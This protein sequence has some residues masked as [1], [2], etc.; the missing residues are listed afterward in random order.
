MA[1]AVVPAE[2]VV[3]H[4]PLKRHD[5]S[6]DVFSV[7]DIS[8]DTVSDGI[9]ESETDTNDATDS[10]GDLYLPPEIRM[11]LPPFNDIVDSFF[12]EHQNDSTP[13]D[14]AALQIQLH[15]RFTTWTTER[16]I[17]DGKLQNSNISNTQDACPAP[18]PSC[19]SGLENHKERRVPLLKDLARARN[20]Y[21]SRAPVKT[22]KHFD[23]YEQFDWALS[24]VISEHLNNDPSILALK[25]ERNKKA[26]EREEDPPEWIEPLH[27]LWSSLWSDTEKLVDRAREDMTKLGYLLIFE[28]CGS[29]SALP[30]RPSCKTMR[31]YSTLHIRTRKEYQDRVEAILGNIADSVINAAWRRVDKASQQLAKRHGFLSLENDYLKQKL[32][33]IQRACREARGHR[34]A[35]VWEVRQES[36]RPIRSAPRRVKRYVHY[37]CSL[38]IAS[39]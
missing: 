3:K 26:R 19:A 35:D 18:P 17:I 14:L 25:E 12:T 20:A 34:S 11:R 4:F 23:A 6:E 16:N 27:K 32:A 37:D 33:C 36:N 39:H 15:E 38:V 8:E 5:T 24:S 2:E 31:A 10:D 21:L 9:N 30:G 13:M 1:T 22:I 28:D 7:D 29:Q